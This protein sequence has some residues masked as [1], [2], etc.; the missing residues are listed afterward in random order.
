MKVKIIKPHLEYKPGDE[1]DF[2]EG[3]AGYLIKVKVATI[4]TPTDE[5]LEKELTKKLKAKKKK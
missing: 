3:I 2:D 5:D 1:V 4:E